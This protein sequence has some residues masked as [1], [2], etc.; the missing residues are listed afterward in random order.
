MEYT[1][2]EFGALTGQKTNNLAKYIERRQVNVNEKGL[3]DSDDDVNMA[4]MAKHYR[5]TDENEEEI[6][7]T[8]AKSRKKAKNPDFPEF[9]DGWDGKTDSRGYPVITKE[10]D[11]PGKDGVPAISVSEKA[12]KH[13]QAEKYRI[14][15]QLRE[16]DFQKKM[17]ALIPTELMGAVIAQQSKSFSSAFRQSLSRMVDMLVIKYK[18]TGADAADMR[19]MVVDT[20]NKSIE[21]ALT[22]SK[23]EIKAIAKEFSE[24]KKMEVD[25]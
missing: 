8:A 4:F 20:V 3:I 7:A 12:F 19:K 10:R 18:L 13:W 22:S 25:N 2:K 11:R 15:G 1:K 9:D 23:K 24:K 14:D 21:E 5:D 6:V 16:L 17:G